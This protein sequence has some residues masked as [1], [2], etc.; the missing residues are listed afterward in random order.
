[1]KVF[2]ILFCYSLVFSVSV[3]IKSF[4]KIQLNVLFMLLRHGNIFILSTVPRIK[5]TDDT[6]IYLQPCVQ[7][8][9]R[10][11]FQQL[12]VFCHPLLASTGMLLAMQ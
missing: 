5:V 4:F 3:T 1:M 12:S 6:K 11:F 7:G 2:V 10:F 8:K 9:L